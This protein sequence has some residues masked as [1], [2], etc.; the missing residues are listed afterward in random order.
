MYVYGLWD[1][2]A[3][4]LQIVVLCRNNDVDFHAVLEDF[5]LIVVNKSGVAVDQ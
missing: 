4:V 3:G 5:H 2:G 1:D